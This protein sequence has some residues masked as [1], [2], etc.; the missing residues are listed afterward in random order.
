MLFV[1]F[2]LLLLIF[3]FC[4]LFFSIWLT[5]VLA[6]S[7]LGFCCTWLCASSTWW[8]FHNREVFRYY[9]FQIFCQALSLYLLFRTP[10][11]GM[12]VHLILSQSSLKLSSFLFILFSF[13]FFFCSTAVIAT[14]LSS[15]SLI[16]SSATL[17]LLLS[18]SSVFFSYC[19][20]HSVCSLYHLA[21]GW[22]FLVSSW[23]VPIFFFQDFG[24][25]L[26]SLHAVLFQVHCLSPLSFLLLF[27]HLE[28]IP[29][30]SHFVYLSLFVVP[31]ATGL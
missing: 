9:I 19:I 25:S 23:L 16:H 10:I 13:V 3:S 11:T 14:I 22:T 5:C 24:S 1:A 29:L 21:L 26:L 7:S 4:L 20:F 31:L 30:S 8:L 2:P 15:S 28:P 27:L 17:I 18:P 6:H 12:L